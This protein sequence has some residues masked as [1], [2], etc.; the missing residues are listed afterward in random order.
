[1]YTI[2][3][4]FQFSASHQLD[5]LPEEH[6]CSRLHGHN[7]IVIV[8]LFD[9]V[10]NDGFVVDYNDLWE[11]RA[12]L[13]GHFDHRHL[14]DVV[15]FYPTAELLAQHFYDWCHKAWPQCIA[16]TVKETPKTSARY[17]IFR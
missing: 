4:E 11:F 17:G 1:M 9:D 2:T 16:V 8:E 15:P 3:K 14:N 6:P 5:H 10:L 13:D 7:Y 12:Y